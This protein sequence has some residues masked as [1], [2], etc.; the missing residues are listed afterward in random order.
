MLWS[1]LR[2]FEK[3]SLGRRSSFAATELAEALKGFE[4]GSFLI[5]GTSS[6]GMKMYET[7]FWQVVFL[8]IR[9][10]SAAPWSE[11]GARSCFAALEGHRGFGGEKGRLQG[12]FKTRSASEVIKE[13][14]PGDAFFIIRSGDAA[15]HR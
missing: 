8:R 5:F 7:A 10:L 15:R 12:L 13:G 11:C 2:E 6:C 4:N 9:L 14:D 1:S 3:C